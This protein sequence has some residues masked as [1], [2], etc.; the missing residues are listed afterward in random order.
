MRYAHQVA[1][2]YGNRAVTSRADVLLARFIRLNAP[3]FNGAVKT[4]PHRRRGS[5]RRRPALLAL[6]LS[7]STFG[8]ARKAHATSAVMMANALAMTT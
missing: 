8:H 2:A 3:H 5:L 4:V 7:G 1:D 6:A